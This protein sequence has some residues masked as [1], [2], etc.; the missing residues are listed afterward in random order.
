MSVWLSICLC[1]HWA[2]SLER[3]QRA[4]NFDPDGV[5]GGPIFAPPSTSVRFQSRFELAEIGGG[6]C[7]NY[8][9][10]HWDYRMVPASTTHYVRQHSIHVRVYIVRTGARGSP[11]EYVWI[12][13]M[14]C[15]GTRRSPV[16][17]VWLY[18]CA[19][20]LCGVRMAYLR[21]RFGHRLL[22]PVLV[23][24]MLSPRFR[25]LTRL[26]YNMYLNTY[27]RWS[28]HFYFCLR[29]TICFSH[30]E[31]YLLFYL[32]PSWGNLPL[33]SYWSLSCD[34]GLHCSDELMW[35][36]QRAFIW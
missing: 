10:R 33:Q 14:V 36:Q 7:S 4:T 20:P 19:R 29:Y 17:Y 30:C 12:Q 22:H 26:V 23:A 11:V 18:E 5:C 15:T 16:E 28:H 31:Y 8:H 9:R 1:V 32:L 24:I 21:F 34:H 35:E 6:T 3:H 2:L 25:L 27:V 13:Y